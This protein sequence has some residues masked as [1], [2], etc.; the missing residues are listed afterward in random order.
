MLNSTLGTY[1]TYK[2]VLPNKSF[3]PGNYKLVVTTP[4]SNFFGVF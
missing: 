2:Y 3:P 4:Y 1:T